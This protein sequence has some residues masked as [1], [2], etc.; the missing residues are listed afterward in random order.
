MT[1]NRQELRQLDQIQRWL[2]AVITHPDGVEAALSSPEA[3]VEINVAPDRIEEIVEPSK[4]RTSVERLDV[5]ANAYYARLLECLRDEFPA[6][7]HAVG[8]EV[9]DGLAFGYLQSYPS[10]S[11][12]LAELSRQFAQYLEETRPRDEDETGGNPSWP[13]FMID[14]VRL[15]RCY[16]EVFDGP[17]TERISVLR[18]EDVRDVAPDAW[19]RARLIPVPCLRLLALRYPVHEYAT[20]VRENQDPELPDPQP[21]WLAVNRINY[22]VRRWPLTRVQFELL[23]ALI[24]GETVGTAIERAANLAVESGESVDRLAESLR[25]WFAEWSAAGF[26]QAIELSDSEPA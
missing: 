6:L 14:L 10:R 9:F 11:Y 16:T 17:G 4:R 8:E 1:G 25:D 22:V 18:P 24:V 12:T 26:F 21:T 20:A 13:D 3:R 23:N 5:Y 2:Q 19:I 7:L 15:E